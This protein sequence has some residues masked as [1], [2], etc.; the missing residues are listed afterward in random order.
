M[1]SVLLGP[2]RTPWVSWLVSRVPALKDR[3]LLGPGM[4]PSVEV[5][6]QIKV[7]SIIAVNGW[8][9]LGS[10]LIPFLSPRILWRVPTDFGTEAAVY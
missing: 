2:I 7:K 9:R 6:Q 10:G 8:P 4:C 5:K 3:A 1:S